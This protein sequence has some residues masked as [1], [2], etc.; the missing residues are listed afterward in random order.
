[1]AI[2]LELPGSIKSLNPVP[3]DW[4][5]GPFA[6]V[7]TA[8][9]AIPLSIRYDGLTVQVT[10]S[11]NYWWNQS[12]LTDTG[13]IAKGISSLTI[14][15]DELPK[16]SGSTLVHSGIFSTSI[17]NLDLGFGL[18][19]STRNIN[20]TGTA[21]DVNL[22]FNS[23]G[24]GSLILVGNAVVLGATTYGTAI[25][26]ITIQG[27]QSSIA[28]TQGGSVLIFSGQGNNGN[29]S[30]GN[31]FIDTLAKTG[32]GIVGSISFF[33]QAADYGG[34][35]KVIYI[36]NATTNPTTNPTGGFILYA[37]S[38]NASHPTVRL[39]S[40]AI[41]DLVNPTLSYWPLGGS[42]ALTSDVTLTGSNKVITFNSGSNSGGG[43]LS[44]NADYT[45]GGLGVLA[46]NGSIV[47]LGGNI[48]ATQTGA[49]TSHINFFGITTFGINNGQHTIIN[50]S[51]AYAALNGGFTGT[52]LVGINYNP[53]SVTAAK[54]YAAV[55]GSGLVGIGTVTPTA[56]LHLGAGTTTNGPLKLTSGSLV[57][58]I[59]GNAQDGLI[60]YNGTH[61]SV[62][63]GSTRFQLDQQ[64]GLTNPMTTLGDIIYENS[65]PIPARLAGNITATKQF[66]NQTGT[67]TISAIPAWGIL[68]GSDGASLT[69]IGTTGG[70]AI[71]IGALDNL[72]STTITGPSVIVTQSALSASNTLYNVT[73]GNHSGSAINAKGLL[74]TSGTIN[75]AIGGGTEMIDINWNLSNTV[76]F[77]GV[78]TKTL[79]RTFL[80]QARTYA[81]DTATL[82]MTDV[83]TL[84]ISG[85]PKT[86]AN[87]IHTNSHGL[88]IQA[89][90]VVS[91]GS[92]YGLTVNAP[93]GGSTN[94]S[95][96]FVG[97][98]FTILQSKQII[99]AQ[100]V[101][102]LNGIIYIGAAHTT[103]SAGV[104]NI[105]ID[106]GFNRTVQFST[107]ALTNQRAMYLRA[108]S[109]AFVGASVITNA[110]TLAIQGP[111]IG[112]ANATITNAHGLLIEGGGAAHTINSFGLTVNA[113]TGATNNY[114][115]QFLGGLGIILAT[116]INDTNGSPLLSFAPVGTAAD[117]LTLTNGTTGAGPILKA[118]SA[119]STDVPM[120][121]LTKGLGRFIF[122]SSLSS[123]TYPL[124]Q[125]IA[126]L[127]INHW[128]T[129]TVGAELN[130]YKTRGAG[131]VAVA[132]GDILG[133]FSFGGYD[134]FTSG[135]NSGTGS[136]YN[137]IAIKGIVNGT[138]SNGV[139]PADIVFYTTTTNSP[140]EAF[141][142]ESAGAVS[143]VAKKAA[144]SATTG[145]MTTTLT[146]LSVITITPTGA[147]TFNASGGIAGQQCSFIITTSGVSSFVLTWGTNYKTTGTLATGTVTAMTFTVSFKYDGT[148]WCE[149]S[150]TTAM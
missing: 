50:I 108:P 3:V 107:G 46:G 27:N 91:A 70:V 93:T 149:I 73:Q 94:Y 100:G 141:R 139:L 85:A 142:I 41:V 124:F 144:T 102:S 9:A 16:G 53:S 88:L 87:I 74:W 146:S 125:Q 44:I 38:A 79:Q 75:T 106:F 104:E 7:A 98:S 34:G 29:A 58:T 137:S 24:L 117:Q 14:S 40:G 129:D 65:T 2:A 23:K 25:G 62:V 31:I 78:T 8:K 56:T 26:N 33:K 55:F 77:T 15:P 113:N 67:G 84:T 48:T 148:N 64:G 82:T 30:S 97:G 32:S 89:G 35:E 116:A 95:A 110:A 134:G 18:T 5:Y 10:G 63:I 19:G 119:T 69:A 96:Q 66:L 21:T 59:S 12:D 145:T 80:I 115:A 92:A 121:F 132:S 143:M 118:T 39:P 71:T 111:P 122:N 13:L 1:M 123:F 136:A 128:S 109:Y 81:S 36:G 150:R 45:S 140:T 22:Q 20:A 57:T 37:N 86:G 127:N 68:T 101:G 126:V 51:S 90:A 6:D 28:N 112:D 99:F 61:L 60:E 83:A 72:S 130:L 4:S 114:A 76:T 42:A 49:I 105:D 120:G 54:H 103:L 135:P 52:T 131:N 147:C 11:G 17:G 138:V 47:T 43:T 133:T